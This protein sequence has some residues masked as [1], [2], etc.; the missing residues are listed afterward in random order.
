MGDGSSWRLKNPRVSNVSFSLK[1]ATHPLTFLGFNVLSLFDILIQ[2]CHHSSGPRINRWF[3]WFDPAARRQE[4][5]Q[6]DA[7]RWSVM[8]SICGAANPQQ[9]WRRLKVNPIF[10]SGMTAQV[11]HVAS[12]RQPPAPHRWAAARNCQ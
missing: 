4:I 9:D 10:S 8:A 2:G 3:W 11:I 12:R 5:C 7:G 1:G 6:P